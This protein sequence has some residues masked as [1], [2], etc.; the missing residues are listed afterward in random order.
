MMRPVLVLPALSLALA[1]AAPSTASAAGWTCR[2]SAVRATVLSAPAIEPVTANAGATDCKAATSGPSTALPALPA[3]ISLGALSAETALDNAD[4]AVQ[5][6]TAR[7]AGGLADLRVQA[8]PDLPI[9]LPLPDLS[10]YA[11]VS[12]PGIPGAEVDLRPAIRALIAPREIPGVD[13]LRVAGARAQASASCVNGAPRLSGSWTVSGVFVAGQEVGLDDPV[14]RTVRLIDSQSIDPSDLTT[15]PGLPGGVSL[16]LLKPVLDQ[17]PTV[18]VPATVARIKLTP[19]ERVQ[20]GVRLT[21]R[22]LH[23]EIRIAGQNIVDA[24]VGEAT[25]GSADVSCGGVADLALQC[26]ARR[27]VL[28]DVEI[29]KGRVMLYGAADRRYAGKRIRIRSTWNGRTVARPKLSRTG[30]FRATAALPPSAIRTTNDAR[31][32]ASVGKQRSLNLKLMRRMLVS[33]TRQRGDTVTITGRVTKPLASPRRMIVV[34]RRLSCSR[35]R[36]IERFK[37]R[38]DGRFSVRLE[39]PLE[40]EA[41]AYRMSTKVRKNTFAPKLYPTF[42]LP[43]YVELG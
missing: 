5:A 10:E 43:R 22:G 19:G 7:A 29:H 9:D 40:G 16:A 35:W 24:I 11:H 12:V 26:S 32:Q 15:I 25:V 28:I 38:A 39:A 3:T 33:S 34:K 6:Q 37:P 17:L 23:A 42:T 14:T 20:T 27:I 41:A 21:Q 18:T 2:A 36:V 31:Y 8:L 30:L 4:K 1:F 13:L